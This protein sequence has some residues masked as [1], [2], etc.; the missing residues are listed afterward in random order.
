MITVTPMPY[1][2]SSDLSSG[3]EKHGLLAQCQEG[4]SGPR[5][6][7]NSQVF[8]LCLRLLRESCEEAAVKGCIEKESCL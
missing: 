4:H 5:V 7:E 1:S 3:E 2:G 6:A 8:P